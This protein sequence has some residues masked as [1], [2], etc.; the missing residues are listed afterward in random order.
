MTPMDEYTGGIKKGSPKRRTFNYVNEMAAQRESSK[1]D[2]S[3][4]E[5]RRMSEQSVFQKM[6]PQYYR[7]H[8]SITEPSSTEDSSAEADEDRFAFPAY[9]LG[10]ENV[11]R[12][13]EVVQEEDE[14]YEVPAAQQ[15]T[16]KAKSARGSGRAGSPFEFEEESES[17]EDLEPTNRRRIVKK[18]SCTLDE[19]KSDI[20]RKSL[21]GDKLNRQ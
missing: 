9:R 16:E 1:D 19:Y 4:Q 14:T 12:K 2:L 11:K 15:G 3:L 21:S 10:K 7:R 20:L 17:T 6:S 5:E 8:M 18:T 13:P